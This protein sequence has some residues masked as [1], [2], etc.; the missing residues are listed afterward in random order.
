V[1][2][3]NQG[4][5][6][7]CGFGRA[8]DSEAALRPRVFADW[9]AAMKKK[10]S[11]PDFD[12]TLDRLR[13][14]SFE[15]TPFKGVPGGQLVSKHGA[16]AVLVAAKD[17]AAA[18]AVSPGILVRGEVGRLLDRGYQKFIKTSQYEIP[19]S[20]TQLQA[21]HTFSEEL[22]QVSGAISLYNE[23]LGTTSDLYEYD[24]LSGR[25]QPEPAATRPWELADGH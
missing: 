9:N 16:G 19:A 7:S 15:V 14:H 18:L 11:H 5:R 22:K 21:I 6:Q 25:E 13:A 10:S 1:R 2:D 3:W 23:S 17:A 4:L 12:Q 20:A 8:P 24:R